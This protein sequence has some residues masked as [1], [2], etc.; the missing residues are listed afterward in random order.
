MN[1]AEKEQ[2]ERLRKIINGDIPEMDI[3]FSYEAEGAQNMTEKSE[4][5]KAEDR[6]DIK[7]FEIAKAICN[8]SST[9]GEAL[10][11]TEK[12]ANIIKRQ[13]DKQ[14]PSAGEYPVDRY[15]Q[16]VETP[17]AGVSGVEG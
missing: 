10:Y 16:R 1:K 7:A 9:F 13:R 6:R 14:K 2:G 15:G 4:A 11:I 3:S 8:T 17:D 5:Q 12:A